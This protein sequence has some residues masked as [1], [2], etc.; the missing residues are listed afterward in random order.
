MTRFSIL[1]IENQISITAEIVRVLGQYL[2][3]YELSI[4][5]NVEEALAE[6]GS[7]K[8]IL[9]NICY[10]IGDVSGKL[11]A[12]ASL[13]ADVSILLLQESPTEADDTLLEALTVHASDYVTLSE[14]GLVVLG[15]RL[16]ALRQQWVDKLGG[17]IQ[18]G[19]TSDRFLDQI[20]DSHSFQMAIQVIG[21]DNRVRAWNHAAETLFGLEREKAMG[22]YLEQ[23]AL[24]ASNLSRLKDILDQARVMA[25]PFSIANYPLEDKTGEPRW[26]RVYVYPFTN[27][28]PA[29][30]SQVTDVGIISID[31]TDLKET[32]AESS[33]HHQELRL[34][35]E[36]SR[37]ISE[38]LELKPTLKK[39]VQHAK[40]LFRS[41]NCHIYFLEK[42]NET[43]YPAMSSGSQAEQIQKTLLK[44]GQGMIGAVATT[45]K[46]TMINFANKQGEAVFGSDIKITYP[47]DEHLMCAALTVGKGTMGL[48]IVS[49]GFTPPFNEDDLRF[50]ENMV[51]QAS[52]AINN[53]R[54]F[55]ET[56]R[57]LIELEILHEASTAI[58]TTW[59]THEV[60]NKLIR[61]MVQVLGVSRGYIA[62]WD[63]SQ[64]TGSLRAAFLTS[65]SNLQTA[66]ADLGLRF[67]PTDR[68]T[69]ST[70]INQQRPLFF[71]MSNPALDEAERND[72]EHHG[73]LSRLLIPLVVKGETIGWAELWE[74]REEHVFT[75]DE[76][77]LVRLL[78]NQAAVTLENAQYLKQMEQSVEEMT[79][80]YEVARTL[81]TTQDSQ[82]IMSIVLQEYLRV[83][84]L[85]QGSVIIFDFEAKYGVVKVNFQDE[86]PVMNRKGGGSTG[87]P[88]HGL[89]GRQIPLENNSVYKQIMRTH[90]PFV[91]AD[92][93]KGRKG[94]GSLA[95]YVPDQMTNEGGWAGPTALSILIIPLQIRGAIIGALVAEDT[96]RKR[97][98][99][100]WEVD[101][102]QAMVDQLGIAL[103]NAQLFE[104][105]Y[106][107]RQQAETLREVSF[108]VGSSVN[109]NDVLEH[110]MDQLGRV[111]KYDS[112]AIHLI[113]GKQR[114]I[115]A[116]RGFS[117]SA[118]IIGQTFPAAFDKN[119]P[120]SMVIH[121]RQPIVNANITERY[122]YFPQ[123]AGPAIKSWMGIPLIARDKVIGLISIDRTEPNAYNDDDVQLAMAFANQVAIALENARLHEIEV[124]E[125]ERELEIAK[126]IQSALLPQTIPQ[127]PGLQIAGRSVPARQIGGD[128]FH[129][130]SIG[131][132]QLGVAIGDVSGKGIP[133]ALYMAAAITAI[134]TKVREELTPSELLNHLNQAL[135]NRLRENKMNIGLQI[136]TFSPMPPSIG[137]NGEV[138]KEARGS[139]V[140]VGNAGMIA[141][142]G[143]TKHGCRFL[144]VSGLPV[145]SIPSPEQIYHEDLFLLD[146]FTTI[147]FS[148]DGIVE[149]QNEQ[150][151]LFGFDR[152]E[153]TI[154]E[155]IHAR[156]AKVIA[157]HIVQTAQNFIGAAEQGDDMTVVIVVKT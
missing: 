135:Y 156:D 37:E 90:R 150:G 152:L 95:P 79:A 80:L 26:I 67:N 92:L 122:S 21:P 103:Q 107:R 18:T 129:F 14:P 104:S 68:P 64:K 133:A 28:G 33:L 76:V 146:P 43:L 105:E 1:L 93:Q 81:A 136:A 118:R 59:D 123:P 2:A 147:I 74:T 151:E 38:Q 11:S 100:Q 5:R 143:A 71:Q 15:R 39:I 110:I 99:E 53:A 141:P 140:T 157:D 86:Q 66:D 84:G 42:D 144:P 20:L 121:T 114:R 115:I 97:D 145:G 134:D 48:M 137:K 56:Q 111:V 131:K 7:P 47:E 58:S 96:R 83:L 46:A 10:L 148:S 31:I 34:L 24:P 22:A 102:G 4:A 126:G 23:L 101:L 16:A 32:E 52:S 132:D 9:L 49:R 44:V 8:V 78:A 50:F 120:G 94:T 91:I 61:Q 69:L 62:S 82:S 112:A 17:E 108:V 51:H 70:V 154:N 142:I 65:D 60:L 130:F 75:T 138:K 127:V 35:L 63:K 98:F 30:Q 117:D 139:M 54:L 106:E 87:S 116:G 88:I 89:E 55:E 85:K 45:G 113:E 27:N 124:R 153:S 40:G 25:E 13:Y 155:I 77:R 128:F 36:T 29:E 73:C 12:L 41:D 149:A 125:L 3:D 119:E 57:S 19:P 6:N 72:M 109:L